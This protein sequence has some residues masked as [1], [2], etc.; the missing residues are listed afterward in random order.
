[1][2]LSKS[3]V[4]WNTLVD[5]SHCPSSVPMWHRGGEC[6]PQVAHGFACCPS[7]SSKALWLVPAVWRVPAVVPIAISWLRVE[8]GGW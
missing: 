8:A 5:L 2:V 3:G 7:S 1:M 4:C 6:C